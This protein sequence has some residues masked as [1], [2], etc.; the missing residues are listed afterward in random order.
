MKECKLST[1]KWLKDN[2]I[3]YNHLIYGCENKADFCKNNN[4]KYLVDDNIKHCSGASRN[5]IVSFIFDNQFNKDYYNNKITRVYSW[6]QILYE[7][8]RL[9]KKR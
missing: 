4:I 2:K 5:G 8:K 3:F 9:E 7:I 6:G 1:E